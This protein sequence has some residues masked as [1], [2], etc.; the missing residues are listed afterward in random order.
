M[1]SDSNRRA[2]LTAF[3]DFTANPVDPKASVIVSLSRFGGS[4]TL[5][6]IHRFYDGEVPP[7]GAF[8]GFEDLWHIPGTDFGAV[9]TYADLVCHLLQSVLK[10]R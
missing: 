3:H 2:I 4:G 1:F 6:V 5:W 10:E 7:K 9:R 8:M